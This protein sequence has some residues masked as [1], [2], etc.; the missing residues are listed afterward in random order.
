MEFH[1][2]IATVNAQNHIFD[3]FSPPSASTHTNSHFCAVKS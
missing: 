2:G 3:V 1:E